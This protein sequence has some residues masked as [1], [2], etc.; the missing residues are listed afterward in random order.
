MLPQR[1]RSAALP[2]M[3]VLLLAG[4]SDQAPAS[5]DASPTRGTDRG[6]KTPKGDDP[7]VSE[8]PTDD[9][10]SGGSATVPAYFVGDTERAG[11]R[12]FREFQ[13]VEGDP[14]TAAA[15][16]LTSDASL[17]PDY[18]SLFPG[19]AFA[20][21][22]YSE[23][24][25]AILVTVPDDGWNTRAPGMSRRE[26]TLAT[27]QLVYTLQGVV[28]SRVP[29]VVQLGNSPVPLF[30]IDTSGGLGP[31]P[32]LAVRS[33]LNLTSPEQGSGVDDGT[34]KVS[35]VVN[36][37]EANI[38][39]E[40]RQGDRVVKKGFATA[41][42][43]LEPKLFPF[44]TTIDVSGLRPGD[45]TLWATTDDPSGGSEGIGAMTDDKD[46]TIR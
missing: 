6:E 37:F 26:A 46:F 18:R 43:W 1:L 24:A 8:S 11:P 40:L 28:Q 23:G 19:G 30:G 29:V 41:E 15:E 21:V 10:S 31:A 4:C 2:L 13:R 39:W 20:S 16:L 33:H 14:L 25:G 42:G 36:S 9:E 45:Y 27:Q 34:L 3:A 44:E 38:G 12:L 7:T 32:P 35:G 22:E 17:D 5:E